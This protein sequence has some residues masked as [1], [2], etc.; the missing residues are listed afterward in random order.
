MTGAQKYSTRTR[1][2]LS[3]VSRAL[4]AQ[5]L[6]LQAVNPAAAQLRWV[7]AA[8]RR[9]R[10]RLQPSQVASAPHSQH[11]RRPRQSVQA[12]R[13]PPPGRARWRGTLGWTAP[14]LCAWSHAGCCYG[15]MYQ[16]ADWH[17][18]CCAHRAAAVALL[19]ASGTRAGTGT[20]AR[21]TSSAQQQLA[22]VAIGQPAFAV[23]CSAVSACT[24]RC[25]RLA[26]EAPPRRRLARR[27]L[28]RPAC[29]RPQDPLQWRA[30]CVHGWPQCGRVKAALL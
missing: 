7:C 20:A 3:A 4:R 17:S 2:L 24:D 10:C 19:H 15:L 23:L 27:L 25:P 6:P 14:A 30:A 9:P 26:A 12:R 16:L 22:G 11:H 13:R 18:A 8:G 1:Q 5:T 29:R 21:P 28:R